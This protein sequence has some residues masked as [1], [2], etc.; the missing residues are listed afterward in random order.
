MD[1]YFIQFRYTAK[2]NQIDRK[3][4]FFEKHNVELIYFYTFC[5]LWNFFSKNIELRTTFPIHVTID[6]FHEK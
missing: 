1:R 6:C 3:K 2:L 4:T 5:F